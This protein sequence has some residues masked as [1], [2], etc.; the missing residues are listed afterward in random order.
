MVTEYVSIDFEIGGYA[1]ATYRMVKGEPTVVSIKPSE[2]W[3]L[4]SLTLDGEN[5]TDKVSENGLYEVPALE[6]DAKLAAEF[7]YYEDLELTDL[8]GVGSITADN[9]DIRVYNEN[10]NIVVEGLVKGDNIAVYT[11][12]GMMIANHVADKDKVNI[13]APS[14]NIYIVRVNNGAVK[15]QH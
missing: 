5:V 7:E 12:G 14:G 2:E 10:G 9:R 15:I 4:V 1:S 3:K 6:A 8:T 11:V 13:A